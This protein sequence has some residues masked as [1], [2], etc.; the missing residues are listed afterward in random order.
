M[1]PFNFDY[2]HPNWQSWLKQ[3]VA[4]G[5]LVVNDVLDVMWIN[6]G[7][8]VNNIAIHRKKL[9]DVPTVVTVRLR[10]AAGATIGTDVDVEVGSAANPAAPYFVHVV[11]QPF[12]NAGSVQLVLKSGTLEHTCF[13]VFTELVNFHSEHG[14]SC[15]VETCDVPT[16]VPTCF[17]AIR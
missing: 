15:D 3:E 7:T 14:C 11:N 12:Q 2:D 1:L 8:L 17:N 10:D 4:G 13:S 16:P 9:G 6:P 5:A